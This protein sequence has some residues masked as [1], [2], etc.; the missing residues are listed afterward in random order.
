[1]L[2]NDCPNFVGK[3][4]LFHLQGNG[5][6]RPDGSKA[7]RK[8]DLVQALERM[9]DAWGSRTI[10]FKVFPGHIPPRLIK[11]ELLPR[12]DI[13]F[14]LL[15]RRPIE[16]FVSGVKVKGGANYALM[17]TTDIKP[18][19]S[20]DDFLVW[21]RRTRAWY[22]WIRGVLDAR[23]K[24]YA[25]ISFEKHLDGYSAQ[26][27]LAHLRELFSPLGITNFEDVDEHATGGMRQDRQGDYRKRVA[28]WDAFEA[29]LRARPQTR[30]MLKWAERIP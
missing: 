6:Q 1:M 15:K 2:I 27:S 10:A 14:A 26:E 21:A 5:N 8:D 22:K 13:A 12:D 29:A 7:W 25:E 28:N 16:S 18:A 11:T 30:N 17:D 19:I 20:A 24:P 4:E 9:R 3:G 23:E